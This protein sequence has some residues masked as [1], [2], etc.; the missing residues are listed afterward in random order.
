MAV[1]LSHLTPQPYEIQFRVPGAPI[2]D[3]GTKDPSLG[4]GLRWK[5]D[6]DWTLDVQVQPAPE[7]FPNCDKRDCVALGEADLTW[8]EGNEDAPPALT[9]SVVRD[10]ELRSVSYEGGMQGDPRTSLLP[11]DLMELEEIVTDPAFSRETTTGAVEAGERL[12]RDGVAG[13]RVKLQRLREPEPAPKTTPRA[14]AAAVGEYFARMGQ[15]DVIRSGRA[16]VFVEPGGA[17]ED[18]VGVSLELRY[19]LTL[20]VSVIDSEGKALNACQP[21]LTCW[22]WDGSLHAGREGLGGAFGIFEGHAVHTWLEGSGVHATTEDWFLQSSPDDHAR[23]LQMDA[24]ALAALDGG[25]GSEG[26]EGVGPETTP[27]LVTA[28]DELSWFQD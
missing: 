4:G 14:L 28:G 20:H 2:D 25:G 12:A 15:E 26:V 19:G 3:M 22:D 16:D 17:V 9:V 27:Q 18:A 6:P 10:G 24:A 11:F 21:T 7:E 8:Q 23:T 1:A 5:P 13:S